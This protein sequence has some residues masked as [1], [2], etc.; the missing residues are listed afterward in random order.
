MNTIKEN[1]RKLAA[2]KVDEATQ[3]RLHFNDETANKLLREA[4]E[5][6]HEAGEDGEAQA[7]RMLIVTE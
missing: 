3:A 5:L 4:A 6:Y 2:R 1:Y 7:C